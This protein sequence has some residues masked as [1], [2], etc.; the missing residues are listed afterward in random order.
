MSDI[1]EEQLPTG[2]NLVPQD[3]GIFTWDL[4]TNILY[5]DGALAA[6]FGL[7]P[8]KAIAGLP[9]QAYTAK[10]HEEDRAD[11]AKAIGAAIASGEPYHEE[12]RVFDERG[13]VRRVMA[14]GR[15]FRDESR[16]PVQYAGI[17]FPVAETVE[18]A[19]P[20]LSHVAL[21]HGYAVQTGR[22]MVAE[23]LE[24]ILRHLV[25]GSDRG[26]RPAVH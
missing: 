13:E 14:F 5:A 16:E 22:T 19:D 17:V 3:S 21:A 8:A 1:Q 23:A 11:V 7:E 9:L 26:S 12:Y 24:E 20:V 15:C 6:L 4:R 10:I 18:D 2:E 25:E